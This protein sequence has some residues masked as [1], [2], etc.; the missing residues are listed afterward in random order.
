M[1]NAD[2]QV[3]ENL[4]YLVR[5][6]HPRRDCHMHMYM[7]HNPRRDSMHDRMYSRD[8]NRRTCDLVEM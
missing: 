1:H 6:H 3:L 7:M 2:T 8:S 4:V 5:D